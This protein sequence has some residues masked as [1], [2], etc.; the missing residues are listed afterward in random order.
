MVIYVFVFSIFILLILLHRRINRISTGV[1][2]LSVIQLK[3]FDGL[4]DDVK[5]MYKVLIL[6]SWMQA[7]NLALNEEFEKSGIAQFYR[8]NKEKVTRLNELYLQIAKLSLKNS[9]GSLGDDFKLLM[10]NANL[11]RLIQDAESKVVEL[12][13]LKDPT[14]VTISG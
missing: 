6:E 1:N 7:F 4:S 2:S 11:D 14:Q 12:E 5:E 13:A 10:Y 9:A 3:E 8:E